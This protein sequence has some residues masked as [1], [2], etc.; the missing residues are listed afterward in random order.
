MSTAVRPPSR[1]RAGVP[2]LAL[3]AALV[4]A[5]CSEGETP[6][7]PSPEPSQSLAEPDEAPTLAAAPVT[8]LGRVTG[9]LSRQDRRRVQARVSAVA[10]DWLEAAY[11]GGRYPREG[12]GAAF[13]GFSRGARA[14]A[15]RDLRVL[16][17]KPIGGRVSEVVPKRIEVRTDLLAVDRRAVGATAHVRTTFTTTGQAERRVR[18]AGRLMLTRRDGPWQV[19]AYHVNRGV[20]R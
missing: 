2:A 17:N 9:R 3:A 18:V 5:G 1:R 19:F 7:S 6:A 8:E 11:V 10:V 16:T 15:R 14:E 12:F 4:V 20:Q 13:A